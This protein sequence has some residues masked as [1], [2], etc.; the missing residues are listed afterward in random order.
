MK[1]LTKKEKENLIDYMHYDLPIRLINSAVKSLKLSYY[2]Y[3]VI[4]LIVFIL[5]LT[6]LVLCW[7][8]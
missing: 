2:L 7:I 1:K 8:K 5:Q 3:I 6:F 4:C